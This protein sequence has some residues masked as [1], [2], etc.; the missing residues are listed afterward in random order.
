MI[1]DLKH[2]MAE[3]DRFQ[4]RHRK[5][6][7]PTHKTEYNRKRNIVNSHVKKA[8]QDYFKNLLLNSAQDPDN[9]WTNLKKFFPSKQRDAAKRFTINSVT[10]ADT[11][12]VAN[13]FSTFFNIVSKLKY[14]SFN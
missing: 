8:K 12:T 4:H 5:S 9:F 3:H 14:T 2:E 7:L 10:T 6:K 13:A 1:P 11:N